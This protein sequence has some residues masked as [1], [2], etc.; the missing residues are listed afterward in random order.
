VS[1]DRARRHRS[2]AG[3]TLVELL[4]ASALGFIVMSGLTSVVLT[5]YRASQTASSRVEASGQILGFQQTASDDFAT[6]SLPVPPGG[7][8]T[9]SAPCTHDPIN[10]RGCKMTNL[11]TPSP[12]LRTV[13][14]TWPAGSDLVNRK[15]GAGSASPAATSVTAFSWYVDGTAP[16]QSVVVSLSVTL[17]TVSQSQT[18]RFL[19][20]VG[21]ALPPNVSSP[22]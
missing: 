8:G 5:T 6:S 13:S 17:G 1:P 18:M 9:S 21:S 12:Q 7:C 22:C 4:I 20:R 11:A 3:F 16:Y 2:Q 19:P 15:V 14:Y 10:L